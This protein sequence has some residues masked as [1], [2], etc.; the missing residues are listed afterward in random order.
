MRVIL[1]SC[2]LAL[3][4]SWITASRAVAGLVPSVFG[5]RIPCVVQAS[6]VQYCAGTLTTRVETWDGVPL[7]A[8]VTLPPVTVGGPYPLIV[9]LPGWNQDKGGAPFTE[10]ALDGYAVLSYAPRG[11]QLSCGT[12]LARVPDPTLANP[13]ACIE[14]GWIRIADV[15]YE[16]RDTQYL[17]GRLADEGLVIP[18]R[19][20]ARGES[21]GG[22]QSMMLAALRDRT[23]LPDGTLVPWTSP[24]GRPMRL[25]AAAPIIPWSDLAY[26]LVPTGR[27]L[28]YQVLNP[29]GAPTG[30][31]KQSL[32]SFLLAT[33]LENGFYAPP[34]ADPDADFVGWTVRLDAGEPY[35]GD[36][37]IAHFVDEV[38]RHHSPYYV[39]DSVEPAPM[40]IYNAW[41]DDLFPVDEAL[42]FWRKTR[43]K[44]PNAEMALQFSDGFGHW[45]ASLGGN[46][47]NEQVRTLDLFARH[48]KGIGGPLP[49][50]ETYTQ[51]C[52]GHPKGPFAA[53]DWDAI[54]PG[55]VRFADAAPRVFTSAGGNPATAAVIEPL[56]GQSSCRALPTVVDPGAATYVLPAAAGAGYTLM[57]A[58]TVIAVLDVSGEFPEVVARLWDVGT[59]GNQTLVARSVYRPRGDGRSEVFQLHANGWL[60]AG[61]HVPKLELLG[62]EA[63]FAQASNG[64]FTVT[65]HDLALRLP[66]LEP[67]DG[68]VILPPTV[69]LACPSTPS[70]G[71]RNVGR[72]TLA[73]TDATPD[74][75]DRL[76]WMTKQGTGTTPADL[77]D[78]RNTTGYALCVYDGG[79]GLHTATAPAGGTCAGRACWS[80]AARGFRYRDKDRTPD[81]IDR[82]TL[83]V[84][85]PGDTRIAIKALGENLDTPA[86]PLALPVTVELRNADGVCW[87]STFGAA[88]RNAAG[89]FRAPN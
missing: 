8:S 40:F 7:D 51:T 62:R 22:A 88:G 26:A 73:V 79:G 50:L 1:R 84:R 20:G 65:A 23:M 52:D 29:Y 38:T 49:P 15:R 16:V 36:P 64:T 19:I 57:G 32:V 35:D 4:V 43:A 82:L 28:D 11:F 9:D 89:R 58:P 55:E 86:I 42:R 81:G 70:A 12:P 53:V 67:P 25:A 5:G 45:R 39:D 61:G 34:G 27:T 85:G 60:F 24:G 33:G 18:D 44:Y 77:G 3:I 6:G 41:T 48:L 56:S 63:P 75:H 14:R 69:P 46:K 37:L 31:T 71:C 78:P 21:Y 80:S 83:D 72:A 68:G 59:D 76:V 10:E 30:I 2:A 47:H 74:T 66:V 17:A 54:H 87:Q 13:T